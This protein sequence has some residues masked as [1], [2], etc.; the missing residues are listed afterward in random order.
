MSITTLEAVEVLDFDDEGAFLTVS[1]A[2]RLEKILH[3]NGLPTAYA[4]DWA[5]GFVGVDVPLENAG[6]TIGLGWN[7]D[8]A[9]SHPT[10][11]HWIVL[12]TTDEFDTETLETDLSLEAA[13]ELVKVELARDPYGEVPSRCPACGDIIDSCQGHGEIG[14]P[15]GHETLRLHDRGIHNVCHPDGCDEKNDDSPY[16]GLGGT[17]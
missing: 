11:D 17:K 2:E 9:G 16:T 13:V 15:Y 10:G 3:E 8:A 5:G 7:G 6:E 4:A 1:G 14:D 12:R